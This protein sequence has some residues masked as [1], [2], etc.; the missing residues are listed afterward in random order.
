MAKKKRKRNT[1]HSHITKLNNHRCALLSLK[2]TIYY[3]K[4]HGARGWTQRIPRVLPQCSDAILARFAKKSIAVFLSICARLGTCVG[5]FVCEKERVRER[6]YMCEY[7]L[8]TSQPNYVLDRC[9]RYSSPNFSCAS[10]SWV[11]DQRSEC[12]SGLT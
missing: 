2:R 11:D 10:R 7:V 3:K 6:E 8:Y 5:K 1:L 9:A 12:K 4:A